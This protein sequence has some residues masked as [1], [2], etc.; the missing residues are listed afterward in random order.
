M[1]EHALTPAVFLDRDGVL[2]RPVVRDGKPYPPATLEEFELYPEAAEACRRL[3]EAG[4]AL[5]V[6]TNQPDVGRGTQRL[7]VVEAMHARL[8][9]AL[10]IDRIEVCYE[11]GGPGDAS[12]FRKP[13]PGMLLRAARELSLDLARSFMVGDRWRDIDCGHAAGC[14]TIFIDRG[15]TEALKQRPHFQVGNLTEAANIILDC[16]RGVR[17]VPR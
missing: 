12:D 13:R 1:G 10:P 6:A 8:L 17:M 4:L 3:K 16:V 14:A 15:Y 11:A 9:A 2:N 5:V 7:E